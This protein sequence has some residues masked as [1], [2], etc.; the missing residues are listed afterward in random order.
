MKLQIKENLKKQIKSAIEE[1]SHRFEGQFGD[2][3]SI[4]PHSKDE[5]EERQQDL[6]LKNIHLQNQIL[7]KEFEQQKIS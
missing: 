6:A 5:V 2:Y 4:F 1:D 7:Q 3:R